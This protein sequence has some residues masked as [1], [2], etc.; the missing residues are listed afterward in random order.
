MENRKNHLFI[1][2]FK[3]SFPFNLI[4]DMNFIL[5]GGEVVL[6]SWVSGVDW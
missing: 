6:E 3:L 5:S 2:F 1:L 4:Q